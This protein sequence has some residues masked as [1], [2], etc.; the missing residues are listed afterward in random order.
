MKLVFKQKFHFGF[1]RYDIYNEAGETVFTVKGRF[2]LGRRLEVY[3]RG[4]NLIGELKGLPFR[5]LPTFEIYAGGRLVGE[6]QK[7]FTF[8]R[9][10]F[11][12]DCNSWRVDGNFLEY[13]YKIYDQDNR[14]VAMIEREI[15]WM[16]TYTLSI[17]DDADMLAVL[18]I[19]IA[20]DAERDDRG[21]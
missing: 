13:D 21:N 19:V 7:K 10:E 5:F 16:D 18:M 6:V 8:F 12:L 20:I 2:A 9:H 17:Y 14:V 3:D 15:A 11:I 1:D 4:E